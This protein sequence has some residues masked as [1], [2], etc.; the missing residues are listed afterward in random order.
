MSEDTRNWLSCGRVSFP[1]LSFHTFRLHPP[2]RG[3]P[4]NPAGGRIF[5]YGGKGAGG[6][7]SGAV[8][9]GFTRGR[10]GS[11]PRRPCLS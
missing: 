8:V 4:V 10:G 5:E 9:A 1:L 7:L 11:H 3:H 6:H 2:P